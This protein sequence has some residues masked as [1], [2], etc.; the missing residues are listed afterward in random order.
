MYRLSAH[1]V[2][3]S[4]CVSPIFVASHLLMHYFALCVM[5]HLFSLYI[6]SM[7]SYLGTL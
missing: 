1:S 4:H 5:C 3:S 6:I 2:V 7:Y